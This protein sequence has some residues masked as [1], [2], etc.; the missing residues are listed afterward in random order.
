MW[1]R[2]ERALLRMLRVEDLLTE[3]FE[4]RARLWITGARSVEQCLH[5]RVVTCT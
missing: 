3:R 1:E 4:D 5:R 2:E